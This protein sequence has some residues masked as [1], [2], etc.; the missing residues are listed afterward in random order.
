MIVSCDIAALLMR[1]ADAPNA[2]KD[3]VNRGWLAE[4]IEAARRSLTAFDAQGAQ[5]IVTELRFLMALLRERERLSHA[6]AR[7]ER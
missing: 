4:F 2:V 7:S 3:E 1:S 6:A 5:E